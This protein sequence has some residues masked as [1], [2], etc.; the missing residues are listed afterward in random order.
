MVQDTLNLTT[1]SFKE[2]K[3]CIFF[4]CGTFLIRFIVYEILRDF[5]ENG[6]Q[7]YASPHVISFYDKTGVKLYVFSVKESNEIGFKSK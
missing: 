5:L 4:V 3:F 1:H 6:R 7:K 2:I